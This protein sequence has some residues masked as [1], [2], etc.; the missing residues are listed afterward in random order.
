MMNSAPRK[1]RPV[2]TRRSPQQLLREEILALERYEVY[3]SKGLIKLDAM[4][5]PYQLPP[6][7][8][9]RITSAASTLE[10]NRYPDSAAVEL[11]NTLRQTMRVP[12]CA[13]ILLGNGSDELIQII[14][15]AFARS[16]AVLMSVEPSF[17]MY[18]RVALYAGMRFVG[19]ALAP[20]FA[21]DA[22]RLLAAIEEHEPAL[23]FLAYPN[24]PTGNLFDRDAV[25]SIVEQNRGITVLDEAYH[26][27]AQASFM[28]DI[29]THPNLLVMRTLSKLGLAGLRLG[30]VAGRR[31]WLTQFEK[32]RLPYN[33][34]TFTQAAA[35]AVLRDG[36]VFESQ[37]KKI[38]EDRDS[39]VRELKN[40]GLEAFDSSANFVSLRTPHADQVFSSLRTR[41]V[42][43]KN[44]NRS[45]PML[46]DCLRVTIGTAEENRKFLAALDASLP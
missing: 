21:L 17:V 6:E 19:V 9:T 7:A 33:V 35:H 3:D 38:R 37:A 28:D 13:D 32:L 20:D 4:E 46:R 5:N 39:M 27:F 2:E 40:R 16:G 42:L 30:F 12:E 25:L 34:G 11:K 45:H 1:T 23:V 43:V 22:E 26:P 24:N 8:T 18:Q 44:L 36:E 14:A 41:G 15:L 10:F 29:E 31:E